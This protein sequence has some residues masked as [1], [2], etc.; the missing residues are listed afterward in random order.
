MLE[1]LAGAGGRADVALRRRRG[2]AGPGLWVGSEAGTVDV[3]VVPPATVVVVSPGSVVPAAPGA[4]VVVLAASA[5][6][7]VEEVDVTLRGL[8]RPLAAAA[9]LPVTTSPVDGVDS[10]GALP[11][12]EEVV[13]VLSFVTGALHCS[14]GR[15]YTWPVTWTRR[16]AV[17]WS[18]TP[19]RLTTIASPWRTISGSATPS[20]S[21]R[22]RI[23]STARSRPAES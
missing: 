10:T 9:V 8:I 6:G 20:E 16:S 22:A 23:W 2:S 17:S 13:V 3:V 11:V 15:R 4:V 19:G 21:T 14:T 7:T 5:G 1:H 12:G 18:L